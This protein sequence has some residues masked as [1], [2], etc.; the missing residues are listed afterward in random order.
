MGSSGIDLR[1]TLPS[2]FPYENSRKHFMGSSTSMF[3][4]WN[5]CTARR[6]WLRPYTEIRPYFPSDVLHQAVNPTNARHEFHASLRHRSFPSYGWSLKNLEVVPIIGNPGGV[7]LR[8]R[9]DFVAQ[10]DGDHW[11]EA[12]GSDIHLMYGHAF[13]QRIAGLAPVH[14]SASRGMWTLHMMRRNTLRGACPLGTF[15]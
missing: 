7:L 3:T 8:H 1:A 12:H 6:V 13:R 15:A 11:H 9:Q 4:A 5:R 14:T 10:S 2:P